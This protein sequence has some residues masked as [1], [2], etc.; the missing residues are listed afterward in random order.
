MQGCVV[1]LVFSAAPLGL[2][3]SYIVHILDL[4]I[5]VT[6]LCEDLG[7]DLLKWQLIEGEEGG[8]QS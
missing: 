3:G 6:E 8:E 7:P 1:L 4:P 5:V 2:E